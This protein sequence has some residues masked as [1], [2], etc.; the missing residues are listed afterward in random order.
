MKN[1]SKAYLLVFS[2]LGVVVLGG[3]FA[4][5]LEPES[6]E[7]PTAV[8]GG[9]L[10]VTPDILVYSQ[11]AEAII[12]GTVKEIVDYPN[13]TYIPLLNAKIEVEEA[14]RGDPA[15][16]DV[17]VMIPAPTQNVLLEDTVT[18]AEGERVLL[19]LKTD[20]SG[21]IV[22]IGHDAGKCLVDEN[23][24]VTGEPVFTMPL[25]DLKAKIRDALE[26]SNTK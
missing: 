8:T 9:A 24:N 7:G 20:A 4:K 10:V 13:Q 12:V 14:L 1:R 3:V 17:V 25:A 5:S 11:G 2:L 19:F 21:N 26:Q 22:V 6:L 16:T 23:D 15:M 18:L